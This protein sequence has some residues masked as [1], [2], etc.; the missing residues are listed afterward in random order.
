MTALPHDLDAERACIGAVILRPSALPDVLEHA[1]PADFYHPAH[2][3]IVG[4]ML[5]CDA[6]GE[7]V[8]EIT[9]CGAM[10]RASVANRLTALGGSAYF[11]ELASSVVTH[12][13]VGH[14][15]RIV[16]AKSL[17]RQLAEGAAELR[18][19]ALEPSAD[20][21]GTLAALDALARR[22]G[23]ASANGK[24]LRHGRAALREL[25]MAVEARY[26]HRG[27]L[28]GIPTGFALLDSLTA[29]LQPGELSVIAA[30]PSMGKTSF[31]ASMIRAISTRAGIPCAV[32]SLEMSQAALFE[33]LVAAE[34][35]IDSMAL[36]T[37][38]LQPHHFARMVTATARLAE[39]AIYVDDEGA[40]PL[41]TI[42]ARARRWRTDKQQGGAHRHAVIAVDYLGLI[43]GA[44]K[45]GDNREQFIAGISRGLKAL[46]K[47]LDCHVCALAQLN[48]QC[49]AR[50]DKRPMLSDLRESGAI[51]Q[52]ADL[53]AFIY[54]DEVYN[55]FDPGAKGSKSTRDNRGE[56]ELIIAKHRRGPCQ[57]VPLRWVAQHTKFEEST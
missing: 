16:R 47:E 1:Q 10:E 32:F 14:Y 53:I 33:S 6:R 31:M 28:T 35:G 43:G 41:A 24:G 3:A 30:R 8:D 49:E 39:V 46:A 4:A 13:N 29:G 55:K 26:E 18:G 36:R 11:G 7:P 38:A 56:A 34:G 5:A 37:G 22:L 2:A 42:R 48:R 54:R 57:T 17:L 25:V 20:L 40:T 45:L 21:A 27:T 44:D 15:A 19:L 9:I 23:E 50:A 12:E 52:D 51:E